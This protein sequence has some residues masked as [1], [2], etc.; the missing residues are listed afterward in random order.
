MITMSELCIHELIIEQCSLCKKPPA[1]INEIVY[2]T[3]GGSVIHN[4]RDCAWLIE[5]QAMADNMG[6][7]N[8]DI[9]PSRWSQYFDSRGACEWCCATY[10]LKIEDLEVCEILEVG[11]WVKALLIKKRSIGYNHYEYLTII[12]NSSEIRIVKEK[13]FKLN[14]S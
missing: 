11:E 8:H 3:K 6:M 13:C 7:R 10:N 5:G 12:K 14:K 9:V 2:T 1:G 4:W